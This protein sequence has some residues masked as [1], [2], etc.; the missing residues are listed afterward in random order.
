MNYL[1]I[2]TIVP[3]FFTAKFFSGEKAGEKGRLRSLRIKIRCY[4]FHLHHWV[5][6][7]GL[8]VILPRLDFNP[9]A[10]RGLLLGFVLQ[11]LTYSD[12]YKIFYKVKEED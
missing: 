9:A 8:V 3:G 12:F 5:W 11:G 10:L 1:F 4:I 7:L 6:S 2:L